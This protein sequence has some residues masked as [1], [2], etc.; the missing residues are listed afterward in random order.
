MVRRFIKF[1][2]FYTQR[3][4]LLL[5][6]KNEK[7]FY[8]ENLRLV[9]LPGIFH[10]GF[11]PGTLFF[12]SEIKKINLKNKRVLD[13][14]SGSGMLAIYSAQKG[15]A[16]VASDISWK[17]IV[18]IDKNARWNRVAISIIQSDM[19]VNINPQEFDYL[20][21]DPP[22]Y[23]KNPRTDGDYTW[24]CGEH[25][26]YYSKLFSQMRNYMHTQSVAFM[27]LFQD[28]M[29]ERIKE[30]AR[31]NKFS[32]NIHAIENDYPEKIYLYRISPGQINVMPNS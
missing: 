27:V 2:L 1:F 12:Y 10:P 15:A 18:T 23:R 26:D 30:L 22:R 32:M 7:K 16:T 28:P 17:S 19:F 25:L 20:F 8:H 13:L 5:Y 9:I 24:Y 31:E 6:L 4:L 29:T 3:P 11:F 21:I 14:G